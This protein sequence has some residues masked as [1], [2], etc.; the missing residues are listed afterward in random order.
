MLRTLAFVILC[1][2][3]T[4]CAVSQAAT[5]PGDGGVLQASEEFWAKR[6][7]G[8]AS[9]FALQFTET[10]ILGIPGLPDAVG[11]DA[12]R[13]LMQKRSKSVRVADFKP[14][15]RGIDV[16]GSAAYEVGTFSELN[17]YTN[18]DSMQMEGRYLIV[19]RQDADARW[20]VQEVF[21]N[22]SS[23]TPV[24]PSTE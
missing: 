19:W 5:A 16:I 9:S 17:H 3:F 4:A 13:E 20:R 23:A 24:N 10:G 1:G 8:D 6:S 7:Q 15:R 22:F 11:R 12:I 14:Q 2:L 18:G 21:Y